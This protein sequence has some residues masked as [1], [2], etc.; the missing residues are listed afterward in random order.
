M[1]SVYSLSLT[2]NISPDSTMGKA[3][4][5]EDWQSLTGNISPDGTMAAVNAPVQQG[6]FCILNLAKQRN[7]VSN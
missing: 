2:G 4:A 5:F 7:H 6:H 1:S 3:Q